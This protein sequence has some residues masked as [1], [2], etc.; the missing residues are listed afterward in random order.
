M[1]FEYDV[2]NKPILKM[3]DNGVAL[4]ISFSEN[5]NKTDLKQTIVDLLM[6]I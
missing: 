3:N 5:P 4:T 6:Y 2:N 1:R